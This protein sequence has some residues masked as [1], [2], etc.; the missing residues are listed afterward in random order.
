MFLGGALHTLPFS[1]THS[2]S[3]QVLGVQELVGQA[4]RKTNSLSHAESSGGGAPAQT[5]YKTRV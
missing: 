5:Y 2:L 3:Q 4:A 1:L